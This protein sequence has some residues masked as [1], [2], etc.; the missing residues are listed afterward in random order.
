MTFKPPMLACPMPDELKIVPGELAAEEKYDGIRLCIANAENGGNLFGDPAV[1]AWSR[2]GLARILPAHIRMAVEKLPSAIYDGELYAPGKRSYGTLTLAN[3]SDLVLVIFDVVELLGKDVTR[4][5]YE[6]R[7]AYLTEI[8]AAPHVIALAPALRLAPAW[9]INTRVDI[10]Q[11][12]EQVWAHDGEGLIIKR[13]DSVYRVGKRDKAWMKIKTLRTAVLTVV[14]FVAG[15]MGPHSTLRLR[16][17]EGNETVVK[18]KNLD[19]LAKLDADPQAFIGRQ[20][21]IEYQERTPD[22]SYR[23]PRWDR[24]ENE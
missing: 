12:A 16:D 24:W 7:R 15:K 3:A 6:Q 20:L 14:G 8:F 13:R 4:E 1:Q 10:E 9:V 11:L 17:A 19:W 5:T 21:R 22:G 2:N 23:H 18:W